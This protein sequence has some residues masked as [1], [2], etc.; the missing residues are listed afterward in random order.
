MGEWMDGWLNGWMDAWM[1]GWKDD[2][3]SFVFGLSQVQMQLE[4]CFS[5]ESIS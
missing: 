5:N 4:Y 2:L 3:Y 1:D